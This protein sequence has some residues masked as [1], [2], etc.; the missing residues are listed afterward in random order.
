MR[1]FII[2]C[3]SVDGDT[4]TIDGDL[5][6]HIAHV[7][8]LKKGALLSLADGNGH[9]YDGRIS[10]VGAECLTVAVEEDRC[11]SP[12]GDGPRITLYQGLPKGAK[13]EVI[14]QKCTE[15]GVSEIVPFVASRSV[16]RLDPDRNKEKL[17]R[18]R[19]IAL[20]AARQSRR[21]AV[22]EIRFAADLAEACRNADHKVKLLLWEEE[23]SLSLKNLLGELEPPESIAVIVGPE[24]GLTSEEVALA[25]QC[26]FTSVS[27]GKRIVRTETAGLAI[28]AILQFYW[29]DLG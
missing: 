19:R 26:G 21:I 10:R 4:I 27:L 9:E 23:K 24:G 12:L 6:H 2:S 11:V 29:G 5:F 14:L 8:R 1:R 16:A 15:L 13:L 20:E 22:P 18:W 3:H 28:V 7:L 17:Q 25:Q